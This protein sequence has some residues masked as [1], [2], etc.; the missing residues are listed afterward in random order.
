MTYRLP[1]G[2]TCY[3]ISIENP[4]GKEHGVTEAMLDGQ[5]MAIADGAARI[6]LVNDGAS[7]HVRI[8]L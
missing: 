7:H 5:P 8:R 4:E 6:R 3:E 2:T 1:D